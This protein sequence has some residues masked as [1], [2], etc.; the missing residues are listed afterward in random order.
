MIWRERWSQLRAVMGI[1]H[2]SRAFGGP[3][4]AEF[5]LT[6]RCNIRCIHCYYHSPFLEKPSLRSVRKARQAG[7]ELPEAEDLKK[8]QRLEADTTRTHALI[9]ELIRTGT[10]RF[11]FSGNGETFLHRD[12]LDFM[13]R[14]KHAGCACWALTAGHMLDREK[15]D[16]MLKMGLDELRITVMAGTPAMYVRTHRGSKEAT[17]N[18]LRDNLLYLWE[19]K[20][21]LRTPGPRLNLFCVVISENFDGLVDFAKFAASVGADGVHYRPFDDVGDPGLAG[22]IPSEEQALQVKIQL[23][24]VKSYLE[25]KGIQHNIPPFLMAFGRKLDTTALY[26]IIPCYYTWLVVRIEPEGNLFPCCRS[27]VPQGNVYDQPFSR[28]WNGEA[29]SQVRKEAVK[30]HQRQTPV[31]GASCFSCVNYMANLKVFRYL[32]PLQGRSGLME[33]ISSASQEEG[34]S[35]EDR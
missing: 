34:R 32:H 28:I 14:A 29:Y 8:L 7:V 12:A 17:F 11:Q 16:A 22:L 10:R 3:L 31:R 18:H 4:Q 6:N 5:G 26:R 1:L 21:S 19:R 9:D 2:G 23:L 33:K 27:F 20:K 24:E 15:I 25:S 13:A 30:I 35:A